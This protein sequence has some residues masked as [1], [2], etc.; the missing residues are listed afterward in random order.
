MHYFLII[1]IPSGLVQSPT[2]KLQ[3]TERRTCMGKTGDIIYIKH[4]L[5]FNY[6]HT[7]RSCAKSNEETTKDRKKN[8]HGLTGGI[9]L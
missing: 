6:S 3:R 2:K 7:F 4:A 1:H 8:M 5:F 9:L